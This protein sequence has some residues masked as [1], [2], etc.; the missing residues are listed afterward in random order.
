MAATE[1]PTAL[2]TGATSGIG[3]SIARI[4]AARGYDLALHYHTARATADEIGRLARDLGVRAVAIAADL[5]RDEDIAR[6]LAEVIRE[7]G[8]LDVLINNAGLYSAAPIA[9]VSPALWDD[10]LAVNLR[11]PFFLVQGATPYLR[12]H[13]QGVVINIAS[14]GGRSARPGFPVSAP[15]AASKAGVIMLTRILALQLAPGIRVNAVA[16]G[17][18]AV[19]PDAMNAT[20]KEKYTARTPLH[21]L[22]EPIDVAEVVAFLV[23]DRARFITGQTIAV[24]GGLV[25]D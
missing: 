19:P 10:L 13:G 14:D 3:R 18:I 25:V 24:D 21:R 23:S 7:L 2:I 1:R 8:R 22:G 16:P 12:M 4:L 17:V 20:A 15:Y 11:A 9:K 5:R 6:L